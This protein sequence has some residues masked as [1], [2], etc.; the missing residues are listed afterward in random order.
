MST[1]AQ[2]AHVVIWGLV[3]Q[4]LVQLPS[5]W[6]PLL[7]AGY[8][9]IHILALIKGILRLVLWYKTQKMR[10]RFGLPP[11]NSVTPPRFFWRQR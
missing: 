3:W 6:G 8:E 7:I 9:I 11:V 2:L 10:V 1:W 5:P 4:L